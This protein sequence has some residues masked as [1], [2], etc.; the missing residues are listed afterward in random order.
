VL[1]G[2]LIAAAAAALVL[3]ACAGADGTD[4]GAIRENVIEP[5]ITAIDE[6]RLLACSSEAS[7]F[8]TVLEIY[9]VSEGVPAPDEAALI[10]GD[11]VRR[12][13]ELWDVVDGRLVPEHPDCG[14][15]PTTIPA[16]EIVTEP[17][18]TEI[19]SVDEVV[20]TFTEQEV[21]SFGGPECAR[22]LAVIFAGAS[23]YVAIEGVEPDTMADVEAAGHFAE[24]VTMWE[25]VG[26]TLRPV[27]GSG[28]ND[29]VA[30]RA[31]ETG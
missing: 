1:P 28:C 31:G 6:S 20:A 16:A 24:P 30:A 14:E 23:Q 7:S 2:R 3:S 15:V 8:R 4:D 19:P 10:D 22:E 9:E 27:S 25:V 21:E 29:F 17:G 13:S 12:E 11:Y 18:D 5:G 26:D